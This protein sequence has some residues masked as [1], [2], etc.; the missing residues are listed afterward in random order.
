[1]EKHK[2]NNNKNINNENQMRYF[3]QDF[4]FLIYKPNNIRHFKKNNVDES[5]W[6]EVNK[7][8]NTTTIF[9]TNTKN[10]CY[11]KIKTNNFWHTTNFD[12]NLCSLHEKYAVK[13]MCIQ[14][15]DLRNEK[16][17][18]QT[19]EIITFKIFELVMN[20]QKKIEC[21]TKAT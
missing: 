4:Q 12:V 15:N 7:Q 21:Q 20:T 18:F 8:N 1:M 3:A 13:H 5:E 6:P 14:L 2:N 16:N 11:L 9:T 17:L 19:M 10:K